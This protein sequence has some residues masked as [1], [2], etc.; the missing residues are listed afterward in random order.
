MRKVITW[1]TAEFKETQMDTNCLFYAENLIRY[2]RYQTPFNLKYCIAGEM[3]GYFN[4]EY[5]TLIPGQFIIVNAGTDLSCQPAKQGTKALHAFFT[6]QIIQEV[7][8]V[9]L[10]DE[11]PILDDPQPKAT[12]VHFFPNVYRGHQLIPSQMRSVA[13]H[14][15]VSES[16]RR[17]LLPDIFYSL[18]ES[19]FQFQA[20]ISEQ[21]NRVNARTHTT[22]EELFRRV[23]TAKEFM[24][25]SWQ[26]DLSLN[27][28][29]Q[30]AC[31]SPYHFHRSFQEAF[32]QSPMK[33]FRHLKLSNAKD[34]LASGKMNVTEVALNSGFSDVF[35]FSKAFKREWGVSPSSISG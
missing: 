15:S 33:W 28:V 20:D 1:S 27:T 25:D 34:L 17:D 35:S 13:R 26:S 14:I 6:D 18:L 32:G 11:K 29:A 19:M 4:N 2:F 30:H 12:P 3:R 21:I 22:R 23:L 24:H 31:L 9:F 5:R 8:H 10:N 7:A 16:S